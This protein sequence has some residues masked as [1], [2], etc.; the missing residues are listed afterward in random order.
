MP[1]ITRYNYN[2]ALLIFVFFRFAACPPST[3]KDFQ[4]FAKQCTSCPANS[5]HTKTGSIDKSDCKCFTGYTGTPENGNDCTS[6]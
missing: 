4:G 5:G 1:V 2:Y 6:K 3:Y